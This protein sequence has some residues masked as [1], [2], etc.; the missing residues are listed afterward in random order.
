MGVIAL[1]PGTANLV[2]ASKDKEGKT[3]T[4]R[5][6]NAFLQIQN[7]K[8]IQ[9]ML[10]QNKIPKFVLENKTY[11]AGN[12]AYELAQTF[13][14]EVRRPMSS[15]VI[16]HSEAD[17]IPMMTLMVERLIKD[18]GIEE[19][20]TCAYSCPADPVDVEFDAVFHK[21]VVEGII[22]KLGLQATA[23]TEGHAI[24]LSELGEEDFTGIGISWGG[25]MA[26]TCVSYRSI[27]VIA[28]SSARAGDW[29]DQKAAQVCGEVATRMS[30][31]KEREDFSLVEETTDRKGAAIQSYYEAVISYTLDNIKN[32]F[33]TGRDMPEFKE[34]VSIVC[35]GGTAMVPGFVDTFKR[36]YDQKE[37]PIPVKNIRVA[38]EPLFSV[39]RGCLVYGSM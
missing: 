5:M 8:F 32:R 37:F 31:L 20:S 11:I 21:S 38:P 35:G 28:F 6:R 2:V 18:H 15:G 7:D 16:S 39:V 36:V 12:H 14:L 13:G 29:I 4:T 1:D 17:A 19:G 26:N 30:A 34:P 25:G 33:E 22:R 3:K 9:K 10:D 27:P 24:V 23:V